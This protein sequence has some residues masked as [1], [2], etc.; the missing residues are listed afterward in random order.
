MIF[1]ESKI[2]NAGG[3]AENAK[4]SVQRSGRLGLSN[5]DLYNVL[6]PVTKTSYS[7]SHPEETTSSDILFLPSEFEIF[8]KITN[9]SAAEGSQYSY[10]QCGNRRVKLLY[11][12]QENG[13]WWTR[14]ASAGDSRN[15]CFIGVGGDSG[16]AVSYYWHG[17]PFCFCV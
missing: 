7:S 11:S 14:S 2:V 1:D 12:T 4:A 8:G 15:Y 10:Y 6:V 5:E 17:I 13:I 9:S 3:F 16:I